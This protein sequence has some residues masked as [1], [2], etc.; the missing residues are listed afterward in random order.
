MTST[1]SD[2]S[3]TAEFTRRQM[4]T[5]CHGRKDAPVQPS[6]SARWHSPSPIFIHLTPQMDSDQI[7]RKFCTPFFTTH[8]AP[9]GQMDFQK[10]SRRVLIFSCHGEMK[11]KNPDSKSLQLTV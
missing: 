2:E 9:L 7:K 3:P 8:T 10:H 1:L 6:V 4:K 5:H 11:E